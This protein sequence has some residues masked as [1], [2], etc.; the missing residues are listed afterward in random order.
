[1]PIAARADQMARY[2]VN[3]IP[4]GDLMEDSLPA[5]A[6]GPPVPVG[7]TPAGATQGEMMNNPTGTPS[8]R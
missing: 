4:P 1:M 2:H 6:M 8:G 7:G 5:P 3:P